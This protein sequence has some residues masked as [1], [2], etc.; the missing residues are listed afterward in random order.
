[1]DIHDTENFR[2]ITDYDEAPVE[3]FV[4]RGMNRNDTDN[5]RSI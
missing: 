3:S 5:Y 1:M 2:S 4:G